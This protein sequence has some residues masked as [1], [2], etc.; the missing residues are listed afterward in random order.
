MKNFDATRKHK[1]IPVEDRI[2]VIGG[3]EFVAKEEVHPSVL[4]A[5]DRLDDANVGTTLDVI[6]DTILAM[7]DA[8]ND[9]SAPE[10]Y[11]EVRANLD[12]P[13]T[14]ETMVELARWLV[15]IQTGRPTGPTS[16]SEPGRTPT[17]GP[18][19]GGSSLLEAARAT[20]A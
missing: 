18:S 15:E 10:R 3:Q 12:D 14:L 1:N 7:I 5:F 2:F 11:R 16:V 13:I 9:P 6:D 4:V 20:A 8:S 17:G 19:T